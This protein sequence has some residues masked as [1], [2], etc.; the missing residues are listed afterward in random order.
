MTRRRAALAAVGFQPPSTPA[1]F[2]RN[3]GNAE[4]RARTE[5][6]S[7]HPVASPARTR[8]V[9]HADDAVKAMLAAENSHPP[10]PTSSSRTGWMPARVRATPSRTE[11]AARPIAISTTAGTMMEQMLLG[12]VAHRMGKRLEY[13]T[14]RQAGSP[15]PRKPTTTLSANTA[16]TGS[17]T[18]ELLFAVT[19]S[20]IPAAA[21]RQAKPP[22]LPRSCVIQS[23]AVSRVGR[24][25]YRS[26]TNAIAA[27][28][29]AALA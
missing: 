10:A 11:P 14:R 2:P 20:K 28:P 9:E 13:S 19:P 15:T 17:W 21:A 8:R 1:I 6:I 16:Q 18:A 7:S 29:V 25:I 5:R 12:L 4:R 22:V 27:N 26:P 3:D 23:I 24:K